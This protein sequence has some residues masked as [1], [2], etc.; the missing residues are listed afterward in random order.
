MDKEWITSIG[1]D[2]GTSTT[3]CIISRLYIQISNNGFTLPA[4]TIEQREV[5]YESKMYTTP[6][7]NDEEIDMESLQAIL[8]K[9][10]KQ[11]GIRLADVEAGAVIITGETALKKNA[12]H[13]IHYLADRA[14]DFVVAAAGASLEGIL[15]GKGSGALEYSESHS[16]VTANIDVGGGTANAALFKD[17]LPFYTVTFH[18]GGRL[19]RLDDKGEVSYIAS[20]TKKLLNDYGIPVE[21]NDTLSMADL[22]DVCRLLSRLM[23]DA[24][25]GRGTAEELVTELPS[26]IV[27]AIDTIIFSGGVGEMMKQKRPKTIAETSAYGDIG[28]LLAGILQEEAMHRDLTIVPAKETS[29]AT[30]IGAGMQNTE[31]SGSTMFVNQTLL[32]LKNLPILPIPIYENG[33]SA[34][35][36]TRLEKMLKEAKTIYSE[37]EDPPFVIALPAVEHI[38]YELLQDISDSIEALYAREFAEKRILAVLSENDLAKVLGQALQKRAGGEKEVICIDQVDVTHGDYIDLGLPVSGEAISI[39]IKTLAF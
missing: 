16:G 37:Q 24:L 31:V 38:T 2:I 25:T 7:I 32:P 30:V 20:S 1:I 36:H 21:I 22:E 3:K 27:P 12:E 26:S 28:P 34:A 23:M 14:G 33:T 35:F 5:V 19:L 39:S 9:E 13:I 10:Y 18:V 8:E 29:R 6:L 17:G 15:A 11:G 4:C